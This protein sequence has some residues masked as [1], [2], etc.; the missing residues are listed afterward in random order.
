MRLSI[1]RAD[2]TV[3]KNSVSYSGLDLSSI[4]TNIH[5]LQWYETE[6]EIEFNGI[7]KPQNEFISALPDWANTCVNKWN[8]AKIIEDAEIARQQAEIA[9][10]QPRTNGTQTA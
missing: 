2:N 8:E 1:I 3:Y 4:P 6:G 9:N 5:A 10:N 7:P